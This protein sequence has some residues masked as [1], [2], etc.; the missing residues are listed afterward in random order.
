VADSPSSYHFVKALREAV[1]EELRKAIREELTSGDAATSELVNAILKEIRDRVATEAT[2][3]SILN[4]LGGT[5]NAKLSDT[6]IALPVDV[7]YRRKESLTLWSGTVTTSNVST[8]IDVSSFSAMEII[9]KVTAVSG[10]NPTLSVYIE[11]KFT[12][13]GDWKPLVY[14]EGITSTGIWTLTITQL[15][16]KTIRVRW[17]VGGTSPSFTIA[18]GAEAMV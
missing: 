15:I 14:Q 1:R 12:A 13:T 5:L 8:D 4:A 7:Q 17:V 6:A 2:L 3:S 10:T 16:F 9:I 18:V 11:G